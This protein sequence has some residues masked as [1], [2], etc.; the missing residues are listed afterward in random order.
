MNFSSINELYEN[1]IGDF[2]IKTEK[3]EVSKPKSEKNIEVMKSL[4]L[5]YR[6]PIIE[7]LLLSMVLIQIISGLKLFW[8]ER[9][10]AVSGF[11]KLHLYTGL[12]LASFLLF[13]VIAIMAGRYVLHLDTNYYFGVAGL[14]TFPYHLFFIPY[15]SLAIISFFGHVAAIH[16]QKMKNSSFRLAPRA[17]SKVIL[18]A[19]ICLTLILFYGLTNHFH[20]VE[21]PEEYN[22]LIGRCT[23]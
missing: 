2:L 22:V 14:N 17:Q 12:Y 16:Y 7:T 11:E 8:Q 10:T 21:I 4:R 15:Y 6:H 18:V 19:G 20:G 13:H 5:V 1:F 9:N 23:R 3:R